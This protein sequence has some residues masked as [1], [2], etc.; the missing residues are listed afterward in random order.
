MKMSQLDSDRQVIERLTI[1]VLTPGFTPADD[2]VDKFCGGQ[3][4]ESQFVERG[5]AIG[6]SIDELHG[7]IAHVRE[8]DGI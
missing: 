8:E 7:L 3:I 6:M 5:T 2:L 4:N 1:P